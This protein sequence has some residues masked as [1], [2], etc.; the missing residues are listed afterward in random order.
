MANA[1]CDIVLNSIAIIGFDTM[2]PI[3]KD[4]DVENV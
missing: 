3:K 1:F 4:T 2:I